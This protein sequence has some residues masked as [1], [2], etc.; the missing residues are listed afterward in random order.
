MNADRY[1]LAPA[2]VQEGG[3]ECGVDVTWGRAAKVWWSLIWRAMIVGGIAGGLIGGGTEF[4]VQ[5]TGV[6]RQLI[7]MLKYLAGFILTILFGILIVRVVL[8]KSWSDFRIVLVPKN[9]AG[10]AKVH[11]R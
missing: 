11:G 1:T 6:S 7:M 5:T 9:R 3:S 8:R 4:I 2:H 10:A